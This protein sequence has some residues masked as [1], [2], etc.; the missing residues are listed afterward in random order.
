VAKISDP[1]DRVVERESAL[2]RKASSFDSPLGMIRL[3]AWFYA[4]LGAMWAAVLALHWI[5][6]AEPRWLAVAHTIVFGLTVVYFTVAMTFL[7]TI[8]RR[9]PEFFDDM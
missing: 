6:L 8:R 2:R 7:Q 1:F 4:V 9:R 5:F 3:A